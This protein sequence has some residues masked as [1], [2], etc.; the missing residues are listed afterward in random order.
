MNLTQLIRQMKPSQQ[1]K[2]Q[3]MLMERKQVVEGTVDPHKMKIGAVIQDPTGCVSFTKTSKGWQTNVKLTSEQIVTN[4]VRPE[5]AKVVS[6]DLRKTRLG[7]SY[8]LLPTSLRATGIGNEG[9]KLM[10]ERTKQG[11]VDPT[12]VTDDQMKNIVESFTHII[13]P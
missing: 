1:Q 12:F 5:V 8:T 4:L 2:L 10:F 6:D 3:Q 11:F 9:N 7:E 13:K